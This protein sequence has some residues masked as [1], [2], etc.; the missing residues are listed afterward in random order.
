MLLCATLVRDGYAI[1]KLGTSDSIVATCLEHME[2][3]FDRET[4]HKEMHAATDGPGCSVG[5]MYS[6][7]PGVEIFEAKCLHN[8]RYPWPDPALRAAVSRARDLLHRT[9]RQCLRALASPLGLDAADLEALLDPTEL[10]DGTE[11]I[12][13]LEVASTTTLRVWR[14]PAKCSGNESHCDNSLL[15]MAPAATRIGLGVRRKHDGKA[16]FPEEGMRRGEVILFAGDALSFLT[17]GRV[18]ALVHWVAKTADEQRL[19][20]P[21][22]LRPRPAA[23]LTPPASADGPLIA[24]MCQ[25]ELEGGGKRCTLPGCTREGNAVCG[26]CGMSGYCSVEHQ[27]AD[28]PK[29]MI[30]CGKRGKVSER[31][32]WKADPYYFAAKG[33]TCGRGVVSWEEQP[34]NSRSDR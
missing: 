7:T 15:T 19:S 3:F 2:A 6:G 18:P 25:R 31:W 16:I 33:E 34:G 9:A 22:F 8:P 26:A 23:L 20:M 24:T 28:W 11:G 4:S 10:A 13:Q 30:V 32:P 17:A 5:F 12:R 27:A 1:I 29:H 14:Y 21:F